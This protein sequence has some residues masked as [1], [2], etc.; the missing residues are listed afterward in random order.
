MVLDISADFLAGASGGFEPQRA[1]N[2]TL[3][4]PLDNY[5][6]GAQVPLAVES[7]NLPKLEMSIIELH[8]GNEKRKVAGKASF[9]DIPLR[10]KDFVDVN[11]ANAIVGWM[12]EVYN[13]D[14]GKVGY[15]KNYKKQLELVLFGPSGDA[16]RS[17]YVRGAWPQYFDPGQ[18]DVTSE[19]K[20]LLECNIAYDWAYP[21]F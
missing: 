21:A 14:N 18:L 7:V 6:Y 10:L 19:D 20:V 1:S 8:Y 2:W 16:E 9:S 17:W 4:I 12:Y 15:A 13:P 3:V 5:S 11:V